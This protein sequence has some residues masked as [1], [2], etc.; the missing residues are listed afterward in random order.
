MTLPPRDPVLLFGEEALQDAKLLR[1]TYARLLRTW[2]PETN[3]Q[4]FVIL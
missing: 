1:K 3:P 4:G 2:G